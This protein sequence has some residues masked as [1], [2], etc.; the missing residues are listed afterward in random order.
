MHCNKSLRSASSTS[1]TS[2]PTSPMSPI[3]HTGTHTPVLATV[4]NVKKEKTPHPT[5][6]NPH[7]R[8]AAIPHQSIFPHP[9]RRVMPTTS[10]PRRKKRERERDKRY[11]ASESESKSLLLVRHAD[12]LKIA[13]QLSCNMGILRSTAIYAGT[14]PVSLL[15]CGPMTLSL[16]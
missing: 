11:M 16:C 13:L 5:R 9:V 1:P 3:T 8:R 2:S 4:P 12:P 6:Y 10:G 15:G 7:P 14:W